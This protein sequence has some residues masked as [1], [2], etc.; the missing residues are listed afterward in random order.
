MRIASSTIYNDQTASIDNLVAQQ[1]QY[2]A[3]LSS[4]KQVN[5]PSDNPTAIAQD[6]SVRS[7]IAQENQTSTNVQSISAELT[8][9]DSAL[10][11]LSN[12]M[13]KARS[14]AVEGA[15]GTLSTSQQQAIA[16]QVDGLLQ[17]AIGLANTQ[18]AGKYVFAGTAN[19]QQQPVV[20]SGQPVTAV[21]SSGN[22]S[23]QSQVL[24][25]G[26]TIA[27]SL[28]LQQAFNYAAPD[29]S[30]DVFQSLITLRD[31]L[32]KGAIVDAS[33]SSINRAGTAIL[34]AA[35][36]N[37][38]NFQTAVGADSTGQISI[39]I[40]ST[41]APNG[42][43]LTFAPGQTIAVV[44]AAINGSGTGVTAAFDPKAER[45]SLTSAGGAFQIK[46]VP[47]PGAVNSANFVAAFKLNSQADLTNNL[48]R[49]IGDADRVL[50]SAV[51]ARAVLGGNLQT[52]AN[53]GAATDSQVVNNTKVQSGIEDAD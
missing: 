33:T 36:L 27:T 47:S 48:T 24:P 53:I 9:V 42:V 2:G 14:L 38:A 28:T 19:P 34:P 26:Q 51:N 3:T 44:I 16:S 8:T 20:A 52:I 29:G 39:D 4:G 1:Q 18:Y 30:P 32:A 11:S 17:E 40:A 35:S 45:I 5:V 49:Q 25:D 41:T 50:Q 13:Q 15:S 6:L 21:V 12:V 37:S 10:S 23:A 22:L 43:T 31:T 46:D 7:A